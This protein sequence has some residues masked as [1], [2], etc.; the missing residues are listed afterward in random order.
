MTLSNVILERSSGFF[1]LL[2]IP[3]LI[4]GVL[5]DPGLDTRAEY[6]AES[7]AQFVPVREQFLKSVLTM[8]V[9][10]L[11][12][13]VSGGAMFIAFRPFGG[14]LTT[15]GIAGLVVAGVF[16]FGAAGAGLRVYQLSI[17]WS[18]LSGIGADEVAD[19]ALRIHQLRFGL[20]ALG[21][22]LLLGSLI[23]CGVV[24]HRLTRLP[25]WLL[26]LPVASGVTMVASPL[27]FLSVGIF[28]LL[29]VSALILFA[30]LTVE[31]GW[32]LVRGTA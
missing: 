25:R 23:C 31:T 4:V 13:L 24:I 11:V 19:S 7:F 15:V 8:L 29:M 27:G 10:G 3:L 17:E 22:P 14:S 5:L 32:L 26:Y 20:L 6:F 28:L 16:V 21:F 12:S 18:T 1:I 2:I 30:W 9:T